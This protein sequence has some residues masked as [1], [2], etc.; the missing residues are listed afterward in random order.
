MMGVGVGEQKARKKRGIRS[1]S[2][3][4]LDPWPYRNVPVPLGVRHIRR[5][6]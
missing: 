4:E 5:P 6:R 2:T 1:Q 3:P